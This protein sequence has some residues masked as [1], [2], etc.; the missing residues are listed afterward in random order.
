MAGSLK[1]NKV[2][3]GEADRL[4]ANDDL[5]RGV[6]AVATG[7]GKGD[8]HDRD[9]GKRVEPPVSLATMTYL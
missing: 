6:L 5:L 3:D 8:G 4:A 9:S 1:S 2:F 7:R